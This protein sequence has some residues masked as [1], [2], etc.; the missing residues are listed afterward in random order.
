MSTQ[1][2]CAAPCGTVRR[3]GRSPGSPGSDVAGGSRPRGSRRTT[4]DRP[5]SRRVPRPA[6]GGAAPAIGAPRRP[7]RRPPAAPRASSFERGI[8]AANPRSSNHSRQRCTSRS[9]RPA[10]RAANGSGRWRSSAKHARTTD[11]TRRSSMSSSGRLPSRRMASTISAGDHAAARLGRPA[12]LGPPVEQPPAAVGRQLEAAQQPGGI[13]GVV[14]TSVAIRLRP[15]GAITA[16]VRR[17]GKEPASQVGDLLPAPAG[18]LERHGRD[19]LG[20]D[21]DLEPVGAFEPPGMADGLADE[22]L[23]EG[24]ARL[25]VGRPG[26]QALFE[27]LD[28]LT[29]QNHCP[30][31]QAMRDGIEA[32]TRPPLRRAR[33][34]RPLGIP[35][36]GF[37]LKGRG[38]R[39]AESPDRSRGA[40]S[41]PPAR[42]ALP[43]RRGWAVPFAFTALLYRTIA[44]RSRPDCGIFSGIQ[45]STNGSWNSHL[46]YPAA[47]HLAVRLTVR[48]QF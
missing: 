9:V 15:D 12:L 26:G 10:H 11:R 25:E 21:L 32:R 38:H 44:G 16:R 1:P 34:T 29:R 41:H 18:L 36:V 45:D 27:F 23:L 43:P 6:R 30:G 39:R 37:D 40:A 22:V 19:S 7:R 14:G 4:G 47:R 35:P 17:A 20:Q 42:L 48:T 2:P 31:R 28:I 33:A 24:I 46:D 3:C 13:V 5:A 8:D